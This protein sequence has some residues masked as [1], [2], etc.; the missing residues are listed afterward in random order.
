[1]PAA[2]QAAVQEFTE[3]AASLDFVVR[4]DGSEIRK[5]TVFRDDPDGLLV[6]RFNFEGEHVAGKG[7]LYARSGALKPRELNGL[8]V[9][10]RNASVGG[11]DRSFLD[12]PGYESPLFQDWTSGEVW[13]DDGL[14]D[15]LNIDRKT[16]RITHPAYVELQAYIHEELRSFFSAVRRD[17]YGARSAR[18]REQQADKQLEVMTELASTLEQF[19][20][21]R[22]TARL[23]RQWESSVGTRQRR[24]GRVSSRTQALTRKF[25]AA[26]VLTMVAEAS[27]EAELDRSEAERLLSELSRILLD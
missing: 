23:L 17:L 4:V 12:F 6:K 26:A 7:Y 13:V 19:L 3:H 18:R 24:R 5:P 14:E 1:M 10:I 15:A 2:Y 8:L 11:Y 9:R 16:L 27:Q 22:A 20:G 25:T 21:R